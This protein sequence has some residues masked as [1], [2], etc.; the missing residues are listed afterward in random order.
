M[1]AAIFKIYFCD[2]YLIDNCFEKANQNAIAHKTEPEPAWFNLLRSRA[3]SFLFS[4]QSTQEIF[5]ALKIGLYV[6]NRNR[7]SPLRTLIAV[8]RCA[9]CKP[10]V[11]V[12]VFE[13]QSTF[14]KKI[15]PSNRK[16][17]MQSVHPSPKKFPFPSKNHVT[18]WRTF[19][20]RIRK[21]D[22]YHFLFIS[23]FKIFVSCHLFPVFA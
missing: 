10:G 18:T 20:H 12:T 14:Y 15:K 5:D 1:N 7:L 21:L 3:Y 17:M 6:T 22:A 9:C 4:I 23:E 11:L 13:F 16:K 8:L 2:N 19:L